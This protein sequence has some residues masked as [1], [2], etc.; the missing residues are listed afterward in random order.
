MA[1]MATLVSAH[2]VEVIIGHGQESHRRGPWSRQYFTA[3]A[4]ISPTTNAAPPITRI[5]PGTSS[6]AGDEMLV[7]A[8]AEGVRLMT[9]FNQNKHRSCCLQSFAEPKAK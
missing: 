9:N 6:A 5:S 7:T 4:G 8:E 2:A 1:P 3:M